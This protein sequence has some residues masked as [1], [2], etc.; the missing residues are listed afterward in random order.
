MRSF[1]IGC[2]FVNHFV[3]RSDRAGDL[4]DCPGMLTNCRLT[5]VRARFSCDPFGI[6]RKEFLVNTGRKPP[7][8]T[9]LLLSVHPLLNQCLLHLH[10][11]PRLSCLHTCPRPQLKLVLVLDQNFPMFCDN[12]YGKKI[13][14]ENGSVQM[15]N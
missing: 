3:N 5:K 2:I 7:K 11:S 10:P 8:M 14:K 12:L 6:N 13:M 4:P 9:V 15:Y 1:K